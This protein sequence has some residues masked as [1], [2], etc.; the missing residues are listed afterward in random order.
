MI[1]EGHHSPS[2][3]L[4]CHNT[5]YHTLLC[6]PERALL[7]PSALEPSLLYSPFPS[8]WPFSFLLW[9]LQSPEVDMLPGAQGDNSAHK[10]VQYRS[11]SFQSSRKIPRPHQEPPSSRLPP[12]TRGLSAKLLNES[13]DEH[14]ALGVWGSNSFGTALW[15][16]ASL[17][18]LE[19]TFEHTTKPA[20]HLDSRL[21]VPSHCGRVQ[22]SESS[23]LFYCNLLLSS[24]KISKGTI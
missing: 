14:S 24:P 7:F 16:S 6:Y 20:T 5:L 3:R 13:G 21:S 10:S 17:G 12:G 23:F 18:G 15:T 4:P 9:Y 2:P 8:P 22:R 1:P 11:R 19:K